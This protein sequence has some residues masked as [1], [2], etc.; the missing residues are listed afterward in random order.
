MRYKCNLCFIHCGKTTR[1][2]ADFCPHWLVLFTSCPQ[3]P[4]TTLHHEKTML[5]IRNTKTMS[6]GL[7]PGPVIFS[8]LDCM[9]PF[10]FALIWGYRNSL[11]QILWALQSLP[12]N[13]SY[14]HDIRGD[15]LTFFII[16]IL[17]TSVRWYDILFFFFWSLVG[18]TD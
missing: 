1:E 11:L 17:D 10:D 18:I 15:H 12:L 4:I 3:H 2:N 9:L 5:S 7:L 16:V 14:D 13:M 8:Y 6:V